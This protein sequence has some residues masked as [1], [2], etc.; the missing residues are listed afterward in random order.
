MD[1]LETQEGTQLIS[2]LKR[3]EG[4]RS[5]PYKDTV[6]VMTVGYG[7]NLDQVGVTPEE[8]I[9]LLRNDIA[10]TVYQC[11]KEFPWLTNLTPRRRNVVYNM[12][13]NMG[14]TSFKGFVQT[15]QAMQANQPDLAAERMLASRWAT[16]VGSR[17]QELSRQYIEG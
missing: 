7:R 17:A 1:Y 12:V 11:Q 9:Y 16:Q 10:S 8:A 5:K 2:Q 6:G 3:H 4:F 15:I 13:F 14:L